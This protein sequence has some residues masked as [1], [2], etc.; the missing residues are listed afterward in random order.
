MCVMELPS[1]L[2]DERFSDQPQSV[3]PVIAGR[4][5]TYDDAVDYPHRAGA[6]W[7]RWRRRRLASRAPNVQGSGALCGAWAV[8]VLPGRKW[9]SERRSWRWSTS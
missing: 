6:P 1:V 3:C 2:A 5:R 8:L 4:L 7:W 9:K